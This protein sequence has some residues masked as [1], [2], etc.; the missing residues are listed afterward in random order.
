MSIFVERIAG[1]EFIVSED[2][3][4]CHHMRFRG[5]RQLPH[6]PFRAFPSLS[7]VIVIKVECWFNS[8]ATSC[9]VVRSTLLRLLQFEWSQYLPGIWWDGA[10]EIPHCTVY[11]CDSGQILHVQ[12]IFEISSISPICVLF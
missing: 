4:E 8:D 9:T 6:C 7:Q 3:A 1:F 5:R 2:P 11:R 10:T 12:R